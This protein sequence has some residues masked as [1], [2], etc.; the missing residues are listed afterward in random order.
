[1]IAL[2][3][4]VGTCTQDTHGVQDAADWKHELCQV[5]STEGKGNIN[6][7]AE[8]QG[9]AMPPCLHALPCGSQL[10]MLTMMHISSASLDTCKSQRLGQAGAAHTDDC[11]FVGVAGSPR[12]ASRGC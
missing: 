3:L 8:Q 12:G 6:A 10:S 9:S 4:Q 7:S 2:R 5:P 1:M 11:A